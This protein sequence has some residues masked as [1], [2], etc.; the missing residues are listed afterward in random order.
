MT[1]RDLLAPAALAALRRALDSFFEGE[2]HF[3]R[4]FRGMHSTDASVYQIIPLGVVTPR[5]REGVL[6]VVDLCRRTPP[7][8]PR[9]AAALRRRGRRSDP[10][11]SSIFLDI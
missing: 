7:Q 1:T 11:C 3:E 10:V 8:S 9:A 5:S 2:V 4:F 6:R